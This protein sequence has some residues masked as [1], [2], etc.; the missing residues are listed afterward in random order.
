LDGYLLGYGVRIKLSSS[1]LSD[2]KVDDNT[3]E[4]QGTTTHESDEKVLK[5]SGPETC[6]T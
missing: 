5:F 2:D 4:Q 3:G 6:C 1:S